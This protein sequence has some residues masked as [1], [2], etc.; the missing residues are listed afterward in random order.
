MFRNNFHRGTIKHSRVIFPNDDNNNISSNKNKNRNIMIAT[1]MKSR[2]DAI[3]GTT[4]TAATAAAVS[5]SATKRQEEKAQEEEQEQQ[6]QKQRPLQSTASAP[7]ARQKEPSP[8]MLVA[9]LQALFWMLG[10]PVLC[11]T[12]VWDRLFGT[13]VASHPAYG[14]EIAMFGFIVA[15]PPVFFV[16]YSLVMV[17]IYAGRYPFFERYRIQKNVCWPW[18]DRR[19]EVR[20]AFWRLARRSI[21]LAAFNLLVLVPVLVGLKVCADRVIFRKDLTYFF[22]TD[23]DHWPSHGRN[24]ADI[25]LMVTAHEFVYYFGHKT[26]HAYPFLYKFHRVH[27][28]YKHNMTL[29]AQH[30]HPIDFFFVVAGPAVLA[31]LVAP[32]SHSISQFMYILWTMM[33]NMDEH[34]G[35]AFPW[36]PVFWFPGSCTTDEHDFH[37]SR[38]VGCYGSKLA[39][40]NHLFGGYEQYDRY[41]NNNNN[42][43]KNAVQQKKVQ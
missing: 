26:M 18:F 31:G 1:A 24:L 5:D 4:T 8:W 12:Y 25:L 22:R 32:T 14:T 7:V 29:A 13:F 6:Q 34:V 38:N 17:P 30:H 16:V 40:F 37:H 3:V 36:S 27:H 2:T 15:I 10:I 23:D 43:N 35:Y 28:Q 9:I 19:R 42:N 33:A 11:R 39:C 21:G 20:R 41:N